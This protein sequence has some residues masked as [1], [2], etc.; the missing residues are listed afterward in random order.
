MQNLKLLKKFEDLIEDKYL[1]SICVFLDENSKP[2]HGGLL[3][4]IENELSLIHYP[5]RDNLPEIKKI[6]PGIFTKTLIF[7]LNS[8]FDFLDFEE[9]TS[10]YAFCQRICDNSDIIYGYIHDNST[11]D[12][13]GFYQ[14]N[15]E[16]PEIATC[17]GFCINIINSLLVEGDKYIEI[18][19]WQDEEESVEYLNKTIQSIKNKHPE[20]DEI[21]IKNYFKRITPLQY[22]TS[23]LFKELP[24]R[25]QQIDE[26]ADNVRLKSIELD[27]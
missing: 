25:K 23:S 2:Y 20:I 21:I 18:D 22:L 12:E 16:L 17:V 15:G 5:N 24:I 9:V 13:D 11:Y 8:I 19:D 7:N 10:I 3:I 14:P 4:K 26:Q 6:E 1:F 27:D